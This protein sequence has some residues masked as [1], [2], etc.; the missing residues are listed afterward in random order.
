MNTAAMDPAIID[1]K[2]ELPEITLAKLFY[3]KLWMGFARQTRVEMKL[4]G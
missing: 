2:R 3:R 1:Q 4:I